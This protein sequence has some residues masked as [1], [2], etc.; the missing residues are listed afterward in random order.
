MIAVV[1]FPAV[2]NY[3][4][5]FFLSRWHVS[6]DFTVRSHNFELCVEVSLRF[7]FF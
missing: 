4:N 1:P 7:C 3:D 6:S 5:I 2:Y